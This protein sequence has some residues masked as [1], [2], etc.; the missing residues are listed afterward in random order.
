LIAQQGGGTGEFDRVLEQ[1]LAGSRNSNR[2]NRSILELVA[3]LIRRLQLRLENSDEL[4]ASRQAA[5]I[6]VCHAPR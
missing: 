3:Q 1:T 5:R 6:P 2:R 4:V